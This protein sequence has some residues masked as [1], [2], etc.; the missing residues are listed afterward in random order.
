MLGHLGLLPWPVRFSVPGLF[1]P[2]L[3]QDRGVCRRHCFGVSPSGRLLGPVGS[4]CVLLPASLPLS[5]SQFLASPGF[6]AFYCSP[7]VHALPSECISSGY[8]GAFVYSPHL[9]R[10]W[11]HTPSVPPR[12]LGIPHCLAW[13]RSFGPARR[14]RRF[15]PSLPSPA[16]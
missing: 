16:S 5:G 1:P 15:L 2:I 6:F 9:V 8:E 13:F 14:A 12:T 4:P 11:R 10:V 3:Y 7:P